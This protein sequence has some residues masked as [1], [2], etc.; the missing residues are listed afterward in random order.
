MLTILLTCANLI[1]AKAAT[2]APID[3]TATDQATPYTGQIAQS[4]VFG[5]DLTSTGH[6]N[7]FCDFKFDPERTA[8]LVSI[9][10]KEESAD[11]T[12][13]K[14]TFNP[15]KSPIGSGYQRALIPSNISRD[16]SLYNFLFLL[17]DGTKLYS[18]L[19]A[20]SDEEKEFVLYSALQKPFYQNKKILWIIG[21]CTGAVIVLG[22]SILVYKKFFKSKSTM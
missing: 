7:H 10:K 21:I 6:K 18:E 17:S 14:K 2:K 12:F 19:F 22:I 15:I 8:S 11:N 4:L 16:G 20:Y 9:Y 5:S 3:A 13:P 1:Q